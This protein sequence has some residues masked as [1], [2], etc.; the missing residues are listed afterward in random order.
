[1]QSFAYSLR[2]PGAALM[3]MIQ[4]VYV[5]AETKF[6]WS[7]GGHVQ[8]EAGDAHKIKK[9]VVCSYTSST[10]SYSLWQE[11]QSRV[12]FCFFFT[13]ELEHIQV[14][15]DLCLE[16]N[17]QNAHSCARSNAFPPPPPNCLGNI[18]D[19]SKKETDYFFAVN[20]L[21]KNIYATLLHLK[22]QF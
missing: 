12:F 13:T 15:A 19:E 20:L 5:R 1:M 21:K 4:T 14:H 17:T 6:C 2:D 18:Q 3:N 10:E 16:S 8:A 9:H 22:W 11:T 7:S